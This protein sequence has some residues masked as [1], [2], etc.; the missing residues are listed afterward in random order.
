MAQR[1][2]LLAHVVG[3]Q[4]VEHLYAMPEGEG[5]MR[6]W[7]EWFIRGA[8]IRERIDRFIAKFNSDPESYGAMTKE[9]VLKVPDHAM[10]PMCYQCNLPSNI[11]WLIFSRDGWLLTWTKCDICGMCGMIEVP[12][13]KVVE[14]IE[15]SDIWMRG[16][17]KKGRHDGY[18]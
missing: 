12:P 13:E 11:K 14:L 1:A 3:L 8:L 10:V 4:A 5:T 15:S 6:E 17:P 18:L 7:T 16:K 9:E 2:S